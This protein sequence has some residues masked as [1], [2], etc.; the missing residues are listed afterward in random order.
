MN[1]FNSHLSL[2]SLPVIL[3]LG[4]A[5]LPSLAAHTQPLTNPNLNTTLTPPKEDVPDDAVGG[6]SRDDGYCTEDQ[7]TAG[8]PGFTVQMPA[9][10]ETNAA[11]PTFSVYVPQ[12]TAEKLFFS[13]KTADEKYY[14]QTTIS[15]PKTSGELRFQLPADAPPI[16][17][18]QE[19]QWFVGL[20]CQQ[21]FDVDDP[22]ETGV[23]KRVEPNQITDNSF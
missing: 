10:I 15:L 3:S 20:V 2:T 23:I 16:E 21:S 18:N 9:Y 14:Y 1:K 19:Y 8:A 6:G 17:I 5:L 13:L 22:M 4:L 12:T 7:I 11:H